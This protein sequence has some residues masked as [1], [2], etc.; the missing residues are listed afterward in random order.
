[1]TY[2]ADVNMLVAL[3]VIG[4]TRHATAS[5]WFMCFRQSCVLRIRGSQ[6]GRRFFITLFDPARKEV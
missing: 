6:V 5:A 4:H 1:M 3:A 2:L